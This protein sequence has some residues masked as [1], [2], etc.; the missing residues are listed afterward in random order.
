[1]ADSESLPMRA[2]APSGT[3]GGYNDPADI[4]KLLKQ[5]AP[6][7]V[8]QAGKD[9]QKFASAHGNFAGD[10]VTVRDILHEAWGGEDAGAA[11]SALREIWASSAALDQTANEFGTALEDHGKNLAWYKKRPAPSKD[12]AEARSWM[13]GANERISQAWMAMPSEVSTSLPASGDIGGYSPDAGASPTG[14]GPAGGG[15]A[16]GPAAGGAS[17]SGGHAPGFGGGGTGSS[18]H[19]PG[20]GGHLPGTGGSNTKLAGWTP[21]PSGPGL[22][23]SGGG[24]GPL[25]STPGIPG[26]GSG[27]PTP[28]LG[29]AVPPGGVG[30]INPWSS[31]WG[32]AGT[33]WGTGGAASAA[34]EEA[35]AAEASAASRAGMMGPAVG[36]G[37]DRGERERERATWLVE[38]EDVWNDGIEAGP[39]LIGDG[40]SKNDSSSDGD[41]PAEDVQL[42]LSSDSDDLAE[43]LKELDLEDSVEDPQKEIARLREKLERLEQ[44]ASFDQNET[45]ISIQQPR[46]PFEEDA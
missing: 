11:Q 26:V 42:D 15:P 2:G 25:P 17:G 14:G 16:G 21:T 23:G 37:A 22:G 8:T 39:Q 43:L 34:A 4:D 9:Y 6:G 7:H 45:G 13:A 12:L 41:A 40:V 28:G 35:Q 32:Q 10:M 29:G 24:I 38:D 44:Q 30:G 18:G 20:G 5:T 27:S 19:V 33:G 46:W 36:A 1:M 31:R 3:P